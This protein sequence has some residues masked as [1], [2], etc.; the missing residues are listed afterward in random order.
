MTCFANIV[1]GRGVPALS[2]PLSDADSEF[3]GQESK[4][5]TE[6]LGQIWQCAGPP[7]D[8]SSSTPEAVLPNSRKETSPLDPE[9]FTKLPPDRIQAQPCSHPGPSPRLVMEGMLVTEGLGKVAQRRRSFRLAG[10]N[11]RVELEW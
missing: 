5:V 8:N 3:L 7:V 4:L 9:I 2:H 6:R 10:L 11:T 1:V